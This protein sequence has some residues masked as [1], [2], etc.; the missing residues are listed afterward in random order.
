[1]SRESILQRIIDAI[2]AGDTPAVEAATRE[3]LDSGIA[4]NALIDEGGAKGLEIVGE[5]FENLE[6][7]IPEL[8]IAAETMRA[9]NKLVFPHLKREDRSEPVGVAIGTVAGDTHD[10]GK[11]IVATQLN[12]KGYEIYDLGAA[13]PIKSFLE[14]ARSN[15]DVKIIAMSALMTTSMYYQRD[16]VKDLVKHGIRDQFYV[17]VGGGVVTGDWAAEIGADGYGRTAVDAIEICNQ[18]LAGTAKPGEGLI[19]IGDI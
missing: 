15:D 14:C 17:I 3:G 7:F 19:R 5:K 6:M 9:L 4:P 10:L 18:L 13:V 1:M 11:N 16:C 2:I 8:L 12:L